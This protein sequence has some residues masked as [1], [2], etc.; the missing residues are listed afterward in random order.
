MTSQAIGRQAGRIKS[1]VHGLTLWFSRW[2]ILVYRLHLGWLMGHN[3]ML[4][5]HRG[6]RSGKVRQ[7]G[8]MV[9]RYDARTREAIVAAGSRSADW[10]R[11][12]Q[13]APA[14]EIAIGSERYRPA[15]RLLET[16]EIAAALAWSRLHHPVSAWVQ[17]KFFGWPWGSTEETLHGIAQSLGGVAFS[18]CHTGSATR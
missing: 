15:Q 1:K 4:V 11:N 3:F 10:Y 14:V 5:S 9:L 13:A 7:T 2:P 16:G 12:I 18:P 17:S 8:V 6:R